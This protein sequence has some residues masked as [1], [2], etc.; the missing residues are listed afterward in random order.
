M[1]RGRRGAGEGSIYQRMSDGLWV[2]TLVVGYD[3][4]G[5]RRR[6]VL[7]GATRREVAEKLSQLQNAA[8]SGPVPKPER[9]SVGA[10]L[11]RWLEDTARVRVRS[12]TYYTYRSFIRT[13]LKP[14]LGGL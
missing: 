1:A 4:N 3:E 9:V 7:Y 11:D 8:R 14:R 2:C 13:H 10:F 6:R 12:T 5:R